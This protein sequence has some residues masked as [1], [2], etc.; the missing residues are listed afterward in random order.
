MKSNVDLK[1]CFSDFKE[2]I[3]R[4]NPDAKIS[5]EQRDAII[6]DMFYKERQL[7]NSVG[8]KE[9]ADIVRDMVTSGLNESDLEKRFQGILLT[10]LDDKV[11]SLNSQDK[12]M[13]L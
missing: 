7:I 13:K 10:E 11:S 8:S 1:K 9:E 5:K 3:S 4:Y 6:N 12:E 2:A